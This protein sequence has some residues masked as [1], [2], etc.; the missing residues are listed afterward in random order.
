M[1]SDQRKQALDHYNAEG[2]TDFCFLLSTRAGGLGINLATADTVIIFDSDWNPQNDLQAMCRAHRIG[3]KKQVILFK[4]SNIIVLKT[5][6][7][8][9]YRLVTKGSV[10]EEIVERA[11]QKLVLDHLVIQRMDTTGRTVLSKNAMGQ[12]SKIPFDKSDLNAILKFGAV[13]LFREKDGEV[14]E[15][16]VDIDDILNRAE[17]RECENISHENDL[18]SSFKYANFAIDE[19]K[20]LASFQ[21]NSE[22]G[23]NENGCNTEE[24]NNKELE[25]SEIISEEQLQKIKDEQERKANEENYLAPRQRFK[26]NFVKNYH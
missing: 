9:I 8:N 16:E 21:Q 12:S 20:D 25:W 19:E 10:E 24:L 7:V 4:T 15:P 26:V 6:K 3:Q 2:S 13:E 11:K 22:Y 18:L 5:F 23:A 14:Q 1:R 17:T